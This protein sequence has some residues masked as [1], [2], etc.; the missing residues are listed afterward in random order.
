V[1]SIAASD[2]R[3]VGGPRRHPF[4]SPQARPMTTRS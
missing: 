4:P 3:P 1:A 2:G